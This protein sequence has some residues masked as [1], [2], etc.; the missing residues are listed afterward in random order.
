MEHRLAPE[1]LMTTNTLRRLIEIR[2]ENSNIY[3]DEEQYRTLY[4]IEREG[5]NVTLYFDKKKKYVSDPQ[6]CDWIDVSK[7]SSFKTLS[8]TVYYDPE[9]ITVSGT[10]QHWLSPIHLLF[11]I[12]R[13]KKS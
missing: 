2:F 9:K 11:L 10:A 4:Q 13:D 7:L 5:N 8:N 6:T 1:R 12:I 3:L